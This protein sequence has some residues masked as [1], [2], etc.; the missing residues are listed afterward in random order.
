MDEQELLSK[1]E[2]VVTDCP[3][4]GCYGTGRIFTIYGDCSSY[5][6]PYWKCYPSCPSR[7]K[8]KLKAMGYVKWDKEEVAKWLFDKKVIMPNPRF[9]PTW[10]YEIEASPLTREEYVRLADQLKEILERN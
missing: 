10:I 1:L 6:C 5:E 2:N 8:A 7:V 9:Y 3:D 4:S